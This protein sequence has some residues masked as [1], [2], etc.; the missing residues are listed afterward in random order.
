MRTNEIKNKIDETKIW[1][2]KIKRQDLK[3]ETKKYL[4]D[5]QLIALKYMKLLK[6][7]ILIKLK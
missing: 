5:F 2:E 7:F 1:E 4:Y 3:Y 6:V